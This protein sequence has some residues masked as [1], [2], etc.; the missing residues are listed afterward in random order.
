MPR[1]TQKIRTES[2]IH[3]GDRLVNTD[4]L[5]E[6]QRIYVAT[7]LNQKFLNAIFKGEVV[8]GCPELPPVEEVFPEL[9]RDNT[10][11]AI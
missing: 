3:V 7:K 11:I 1:Q 9:K 10:N 4:T 2:Y 8:F 5:N 6:Q